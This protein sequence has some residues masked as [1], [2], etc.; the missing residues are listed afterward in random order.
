MYY[1]EGESK[2]RAAAS[3]TTSASSLAGGV[4]GDVSWLLGDQSWPGKISGPKPAEENLPAC[5]FHLLS[6]SLQIPFFFYTEGKRICAGRSPRNDP[7]D[8]QLITGGWLRGHGGFSVCDGGQRG[9]SLPRGLLRRGV[10]GLCLSAGV[11][12]AL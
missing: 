7:L 3:Q 8:E 4:K 1:L 9:L 6:L 5:L 11:W 12:R 2:G 10:E